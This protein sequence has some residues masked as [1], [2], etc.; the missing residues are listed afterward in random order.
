M[1][2]D[3]LHKSIGLGLLYQLSFMYN[4]PGVVFYKFIPGENMR[5]S[6]LLRNAALIQAKAQHLKAIDFTIGLLRRMQ[7]QGKKFGSV[8]ICR[9]PTFTPGTKFVGLTLLQTREQ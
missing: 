7:R 2:A 6:T 5:V 9:C 1:V 4:K 3:S 8:L